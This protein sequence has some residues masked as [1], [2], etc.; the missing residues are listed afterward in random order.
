MGRGRRSSAPAKLKMA[1]LA[2]IPIARE[3][4]ATTVKVGFLASMR[5]AN[6]KSCHIDPFGC[7]NE[8]AIDEEAFSVAARGGMGDRS[9]RIRE[10][11]EAGIER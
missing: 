5:R 1:E 10:W 9:V 7:C 3:H 2:P 11:R 4:T 8:R 6:V